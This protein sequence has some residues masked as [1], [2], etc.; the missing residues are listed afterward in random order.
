MIATSSNILKTCLLALI[1]LAFPLKAGGCSC[2]CRSSLKPWVTQSFQ[3]S[4]AVFVGVVE[5][6]VLERSEVT[7][8]PGHSFPRLNYTAR[9]AVEEPFEGA[10]EHSIWVDTGDGNCSPGKLHVGERYLI[11]AA[12]SDAGAKL[13]VGSCCNRSRLMSSPNYSRSGRR[14]LNR[15][16][17]LLRKLRS[18]D[19]H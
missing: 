11:Y 15:E 18:K 10:N 6:V 4:A 12:R 8:A 3:S 16:I 19:S 5:E 9:L 14:E 2:V 17:S 7:L 13:W 1:G